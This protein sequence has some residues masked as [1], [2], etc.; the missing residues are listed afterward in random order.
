MP[1][2]GGC[3]SRFRLRTLWIAAVLLMPAT[4]LAA[5]GFCFHGRPQDRC[6]A[7][8]VTE[9]GAAL[10]VPT[11]D[12][13]N[14]TFQTGVLF[15]VGPRSAVGG[16]LL[17]GAFQNDAR[18]GARIRYRHW[19]TSRLTLDVAPG[20]LVVN[21]AFT[22]REPGFSGE[23]SIGYGEW[24]AVTTQLEILPFEFATET[25]GFFGLKLGSYPGA[26]ATA[27]AAVLAVVLIALISGT[28]FQ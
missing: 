5:Q 4:P 3:A 19:L 11:D 25:R 7:F 27:G 12:D 6:S 17:G 28:D 24:A 8:L 1:N 13:L 22:S 21:D 9:A 2:A 18:L 16:V 15:N 26:V 23:V 10:S 20:L 14:F